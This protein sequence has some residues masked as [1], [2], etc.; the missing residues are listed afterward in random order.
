[1]RIGIDC[2]LAGLRHAGIGRYIENIVQRLPQL[3]STIEW[4]YFFSDQVQAT[5]VLGEI[6]Q[7]PAV[8]VIFAPIQHYTFAEQLQLPKIFSAQKLDLLHVPHFN[9]P[10][11]YTGP[12][13]VTIHDLLWH[14]QRGSS[15]TTLSPVLY[16]AKYAFYR[17]VTR[18]AISRAHQVLVPA[19]TV[20][21][22]VMQLFPGAAQ[23]ITVTKEGA[24]QLLLSSTVLAARA[25]A[26][27]HTTTAKQAVRSSKNQHPY[28]LYVGSLYPHKNIMVIL[29]ALADLPEFSLKIISSR[30]VFQDSVRRQVRE[31]ELS[32]RV[33]FLGFQTDEALAELYTGAT[34]LVQPSL[35]EGFGLTGVEA[36][37]L[38]TPVIASD[39]EIFR[40]IYQDGA[41]FFD[42]HS[43]T[44]CATAVRA[45]EKPGAR[46]ELQRIGATVAAQY[47]WD[48]TAAQ[49]LEVYQ[50]VIKSHRA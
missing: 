42:P 19:E 17:L 32:S 10:L 25:R 26:A 20:K 14:Q 2:R 11:L 48:R 6:S 12:T 45:L 46:A 22:T 21:K 36:M 8:H 18:V 29:R 1:M 43:S 38:K 16:W 3:D 47:D 5:A 9:V 31:L 49:T 34:A 13:V 44:A 35:S 40:E 27:E 50:K 30:N 39:I 15:V 7:S 37:S 28:L 23:K 4:V 33:A 24:R 41:L